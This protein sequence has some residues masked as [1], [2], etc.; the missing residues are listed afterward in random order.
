MKAY[1]TT[2][3]AISAAFG[4]QIWQ[5]LILL[6]IPS[7][8]VPLI[9]FIWLVQL[10]GW[11]WIGLIVF[12]LAFLIAAGFLVL[13][14]AV[15]SLLTPHQDQ[16]QKEAVHAF[17]DKIGF[18]QGITGTPRFIIAFR[19]MRS[20]I[21]PEKEKYLQNI[22]DAKNLRSELQQLVALFQ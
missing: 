20:L 22:I 11:A 9:L 19:L 3:R 21:N 18:Y 13:F 6:A 12:I 5:Q 15:L 17:M 1:V 2:L 4:R 14:H 8:V 10:S 7:I 16:E